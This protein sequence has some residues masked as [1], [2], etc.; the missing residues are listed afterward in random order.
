MTS[1][2]R[3]RLLPVLALC[4]GGGLLPLATLHF[5]GR[6][7]VQV[8]TYVHFAGVGASAF[9]AMAAAIALTIVGARRGDARTVL[10]GTAFSAMAA[11]LSLHGLATPGVLA[12]S[13]GVV[14]LSGAATLPLGGAVLALS[15]VPGLRAPDGVRSLLALQGVL[16]GV[17]LL[18]GVVGLLSPATVPDVPD[19]GSALA[20]GLLA[21]GLLFFLLL[22]LQAART[23]LLTR[24][25]GDFVVV[26]GIALLAAALPAALVLNYTQ[27]GWWL[28]HGFELVGIVLV[29]AP[30][31]LDLRR[32]TQSRPISGGM[33]AGELVTAEEAFL[34]AR[35]HALTARLAEKDEY[36]EGHT[37]RVARRAV[38]VGEELG[39]SAS[40]LRTLAT[41][42]LLHDIGK[43]SVPD[44]ILKKPGSLD[45]EEFDV[46]RRHPEWGHRLLGELG[47]FSESVR[48]LVLDHHERLDGS[49]YP[50]GLDT[51]LL[52]L[53]TRIL[54]VCDVYDALISTRVYR[55]AWSH[56][57]AMSLIFER[58]GVE[59]DPGCVDALVRVLAREGLF[60][61]R[62]AV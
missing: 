48:R 57:Q 49:G 54:A 20:L 19:T 45:A 13:N 60:A 1:W 34:D 17:I 21:V 25:R 8:G 6:E 24:R 15:A 5:V 31:A 36:T 55:A 16:L 53:E 27:L 58:S 14:S 30:V 52:D 7:E 11:L 2:I 39:L 32:G 12:D 35:V 18:L 29:G 46:I 3:E 62:L 51:D 26:F 50:R 37:R 61:R 9:A 43:L 44:A 47:G 41:G 23:F 59:F 4:A 56:E 10:V 28:G 38:E 40:R 22:E 33:R 42:G